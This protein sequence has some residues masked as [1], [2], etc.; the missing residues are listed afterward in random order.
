MRNRLPSLQSLLILDAAV[1]QGSFVRAAK[2]LSLTHSAVSQHVKSLQ[3]RL[4]VRLFVREGQ[5]MRATPACL[6]LVGQV[7]QAVKLLDNAFAGLPLRSN[8]GR[9]TISV[10]PHFATG[11]LIARLPEFTGDGDRLVVDLV[12]SHAI[13]DLTQRGIDAAIRFGPGNWPGV[14]AERL[15]G[16]TA[17]P[18]CAP[19]YM[20]SV[21]NGLEALAGRAFLRSPFPPWQPWLQASGLK[22]KSEPTGAFFGDPVLLLE[23]VL[24]G[25]GI[26]LARKIIVVDDLRQ[27]RLIRLSQVE[28]EEAYSYFLVWRP[29]NPRK[30]QIQEFFRWLKAQIDTTL[31]QPP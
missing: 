29:D 21:R 24:A 17:F 26:G 7:R 23:A 30:K 11:W 8:R 31:Q 2:D 22:A 18:V 9:L 12:G 6:A 28:V 3:D 25:Q 27:G 10:L 13:D 19:S 15:C 16:E 20:P 14:R 4:G 5:G 1:K